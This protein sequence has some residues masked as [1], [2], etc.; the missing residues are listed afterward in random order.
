[1][2]S[3][4]TISYCRRHADRHAGARDDHRRQPDQGLRRGAADADG[5]LLGLRQRRHRGQPHHAADADHH[6]HR[7]Q[8]VRRPTPSPPAARVD[9]DYTI[10]YVGGTLTV[11]PAALT[12]TADDLTR[13]QGEVNPPLTYTLSGLVNGDTASVVSGAPSLSTTATINSASGQYPIAIAVGTLSASNY[14]FI[15]VGGT[16]TVTATPAT[17]ITLTASPSSI[18]T[19]GQSVTFTA[20]VTQFDSHDRTPTGT[21]AFEVDGSPNRLSRHAGRG[22]GDERIIE[23]LPRRQ[24]FDPSHLLW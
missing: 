11:T 20:T 13:P 5:Q 8:P 24:P 21:V 7:G 18:S 9:P 6:R 2:D 23:R 15:T 3:D 4:Y 14:D 12:V 10:S 1:M 22:R 19:T 17:T 16:L